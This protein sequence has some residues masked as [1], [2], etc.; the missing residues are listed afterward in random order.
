MATVLIQGLPAATTPLTGAELIPLV[1]GGVTKQTALTN[2]LAQPYYAKTTAENTAGVTPTNYTIPSHTAVGFVNA[3]RYGAVGDGSTD[4]TAALANALLVA[5]GA[6]C[7]LYIPGATSWYKSTSPLAVTASVQIV[8]GGSAETIIRFFNCD[9]FAI[10]ASVNDV[11]IERI[12]IFSVNA[13]GT[14]DPK[15]NIGIDING[16]SGTECNRIVT[17]DLYMRGWATCIDYSYTWT[18]RIDN[19][20]M[21]NCTTGVRYFGQ[22]VNDTIS[23]SSISANSGSYCI[24]TV[25][26]G[27]VKGEGLLVSNTLLASGTY[28]VSSDGFLLMR[29]SNCTI[30]LITDTAFDI[31][32][33]IDFGVHN[34]WIYAANYGVFFRDLSVDVVQKASLSGNDIMV[35]AANAKAVRVGAHNIG[36]SITGGA[37]TSGPSGTGRCLYIDTLASDVSITGTY[38]A[39]AG[40]QPSIFNAGS[41]FTYAALTGSFSLQNNTFPTIASAT[42]LPI[43]VVGDVFHVSGTTTITSATPSYQSG[44]RIT[45]IFD[46]ALTLTDGSNLRLAGNFVTTADDTITLVCDESYYYETSRSVN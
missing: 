28:G 15:T 22:S 25:K 1:Q 46:G 36:V 9:G 2:S 24:R 43:P 13:G 3:T 11:A 23:N 8:G 44:R 31:T 10:S 20:T 19:V 7:P 14:A 17:R 42:A 29:F 32:N 33:V 45:L 16:G 6:D 27:A 26:D 18:S 39:N 35:T 41:L 37:L 38:L 40:V 4:S 5:I 21:L 34:S 30:D 12:E